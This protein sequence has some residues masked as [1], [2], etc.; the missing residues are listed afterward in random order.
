LPNPVAIGVTLG[1]LLLDV[2]APRPKPGCAHAFS[3]L[4]AR[5]L[6]DT[7]A[8]DDDRRIRQAAG[9]E[10]LSQL[11]AGLVG[12]NG[13]AREKFTLAR[14]PMNSSTYIRQLQERKAERREAVAELEAI[15]AYFETRI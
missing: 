2:V 9:R 5:P 6:A 4:P 12:A 14:A 15:R 1:G 3:P 10:R 11:I 8:R 7:A 13:A